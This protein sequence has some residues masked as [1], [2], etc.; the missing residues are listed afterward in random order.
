MAKAIKRVG[1][2][3]LAVAIICL[4]AIGVI[5]GVSNAESVTNSNDNSLN[6]D[7][8]S[9]NMQNVA[10]NSFTLSGTTAQMAAKWNEA[11]E[12][13][14]STNSAVYVKLEQDWIA[15]SDARHTFGTGVGFRNGAIFVSDCE[16]I[17]D[18]N[19]HKIDRQLTKETA[20]TDGTVFYLSA[21]KLTIWDKTGAGAITNGANLSHR[22]GAIALWAQSTLN[23]Y[24]GTISNSYV[25]N[26]GG[27]ISAYESSTINMY[28]GTITNNTGKYAG[29]IM[30]CDSSTL[31]MYGGIISDNHT[32]SFGG[33]LYIYNFS[34]FNMHGGIISGNM[35]S[36][37]GGIRCF[38]N[39]TFTMYGGE[40]TNNSTNYI[41]GSGGG[42]DIVH[43]CTA[44]LIA[45]KIYNNSADRGGGVT[46]STH[47]TADPGLGK[48]IIGENM[49]IYGNVNKSSGVTENIHLRQG[50]L[51]YVDGKLASANVG[52]TLSDDYGSGVFTS[53]YKASGNT[54]NPNR[55]FTS[56]KA[57]LVASASGNEVILSSGTQPTQTASWNWS[58]AGT[59]SSSTGYQVVPYIGSAY[60]IKSSVGTFYDKT[61]TS[62]TSFSA[63]NAG[64]Y[65]FYVNGNYLNPTFTFV[66]EPK[67]VDLVWNSTTTFV[68][69]GQNHKPTATATG[70]GGVKMN[71]VVDG[72]QT[73]IGNYY[74]YAIS[75]D[76]SNYKIKPSTAVYCKFSITPIPIDKPTV[77]DT[78]LVYNGTELTYTPNGFNSNQMVITDNVKTEIGDYT[79]KVKPNS[80]HMW[81]DGTTTALNFP[82]KIIAPGVVAKDSSNYDY[83]YKQTLNNDSYRKAYG[84]DYKH[85][86]NDSTLNIVNGKPRYILGN[87]KYGTNISS[88]LNNLQSESKYLKIYQSE[89]DTTPVFNGIAS[90]GVVANEVGNL[91]VATGFKVELYRDTTDSEPLDII[92]LSVLGDVVANGVIDTADV[93]FINRIAKGEIKLETLSIEQQLAAM[94]DNKGKVTSTDGK[95]LLNVIGGNTELDNYFENVAQEDKYQILVLNSTSGK[96]Y[97][98]NMNLTTLNVYDNAI[99]GNIAPK[100]KASEFKT[101]LANQTSANISDIT[102]H[103]ANRAIAGDNDYIGTGYYISYAGKTIYLSVLGDL[104]GDGIVNTMDVTYLNRI[105]SGNVKL[106][107]NDIKDKL[108]M[109]SAIIQNK[110]NLTT[111]D[112]ETLLNYIG[113]N[114]DLTKYF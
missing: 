70:I 14:A 81:K 91:N 96:T 20:I 31:N 60:T 65:S 112:S 51:L 46:Y 54:L 35:G 47:Y 103:K 80:N 44:K 1:V 15:N 62:H 73:N 109:L 92:Y 95:I 40:I 84:N 105:I 49:H 68:Y 66:I 74:A 39:S 94:V 45:G 53:G 38:N 107:T 28:G 114:A 23:I 29:G 3:F 110:G 13:S 79:A 86:I 78:R 106:N 108:I 8:N 89:S 85:K 71:A 67:E 5:L 17:L 50:E 59:G 82:F 27:G 42:L 36:T 113:G 7:A 11:C 9:N 30:I 90:N 41:G 69:D 100:T 22:G 111:A 75:L 72:S 63:T 10:D 16:I 57:G 83:I 76:N 102:I 34:H 55:F 56:D 32:E 87:I 99:I 77:G 12:L 24:G 26:D 33:G 43:K 93:T 52:V 104:T 97:R 58:G 101:K 19:G 37:G 21:G 61:N 25:S 48:I 6:F 88:F 64:T 2:I 18:L 4:M 98:Q